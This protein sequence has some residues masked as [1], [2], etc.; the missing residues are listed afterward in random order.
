MDCIGVQVLNGVNIYRIVLRNR[1]C[2]LSDTEY[3]CAWSGPKPVYHLDIV[4]ATVFIISMH[5][6]IMIIKNPNIDKEQLYCDMTY[7]IS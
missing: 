4:P 7:I 5:Y 1:L 6:M 2:V 3:P